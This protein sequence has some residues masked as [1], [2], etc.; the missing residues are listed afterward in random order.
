MYCSLQAPLS[1]AL[2]RQE[3]WRGL[4]FPSPG[5]LASPEIERLSPA[6]QRVLDPLSH[7]A[8][9]RGLLILPG[10]YLFPWLRW[11]SSLIGSLQPLQVSM[12]WSL[13]PPHQY[14]KRTTP[15]IRTCA[16]PPPL[17]A[18]DEMQS[19][20]QTWVMCSCSVGGGVS[21]TKAGS[22]SQKE[23]V[24]IKRLIFFFNGLL[25]ERLV[26]FAMGRMKNNSI[27]LLHDFR[28]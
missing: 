24:G 13:K 19:D 28:S 12:A 11:F 15:L 5:D 26:P 4:P 25:W 18:R 23:E 16:S 1:M 3:Y 17:C 7:Q 14:R 8:A 27:L 10:L 20:W 6:M 22:N 9:W 2:S 21:Y